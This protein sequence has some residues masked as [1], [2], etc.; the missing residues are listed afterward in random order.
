MN[1]DKISKQN[2][3]LKDAHRKCALTTEL[4]SA[5]ARANFDLEITNLIHMTL[6]S[7]WEK[8]MGTRLRNDDL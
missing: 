6:F 4:S 5:I 7:G 1:K 8:T 2:G 3:T